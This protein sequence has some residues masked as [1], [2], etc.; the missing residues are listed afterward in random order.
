[1]RERY[2]QLV[3]NPAEL[4]RILLAGAA[5]ARQRAAPFM[6]ELRQAVGLR[7]LGAQAAAGKKDKAKPA[8]PT[9]KQYREADGKFYFK[10]VDADGR[11]LLQSTG[12]DAPK[13]AGQAIAQ[14]QKD[15]DALQTLAP[16]LAPVEGVSADDVA[17]ALQAL[18]EAAAAA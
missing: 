13:E 18:A 17:A 15:P 9:F 14:L 2:E 12:F 6:A 11:L 5:K 7:N 16:R 10:L 3:A 8:A 4:E 1:M